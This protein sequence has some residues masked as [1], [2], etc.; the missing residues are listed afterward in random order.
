MSEQKEAHFDLLCDAR[1]DQAV[2]GVEH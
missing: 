2:V 1:S